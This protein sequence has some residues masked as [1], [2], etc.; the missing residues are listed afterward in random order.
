MYGDCV[1]FVCVSGY[2]CVVIVRAC[3]CVW[4]FVGVRVRVLVPRLCCVCMGFW[5]CLYDVC[6]RLRLCMPVCECV[7][8]CDD[9]VAFVCVYCHVCM[10]VVCACVGVCMFVNVCVCACVVIVLCLCVSPAMC[11][12]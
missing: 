2:V 6:V 5:R 9:C 7:R 10:V 4:M 12:W 8:L 3:E 11:V 1:V